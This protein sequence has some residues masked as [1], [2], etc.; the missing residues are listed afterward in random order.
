VLRLYPGNDS[1]Y[2]AGQM[3]RAGGPLFI[4]FESMGGQSGPLSYGDGTVFGDGKWHKLEIYIK[5]NTSAGND[6]IARVW[7][8]GVKQV[9]A[10]NAKTVTA[11]TKWS[12]LELMSN[13][14]SNPGWEH[15]ANNHVYWDNI[16]VFTDTGTGASGSMADATISASGDT[17]VPSPPQNVSVQ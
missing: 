5:E 10:V 13:W 3:E 16:E 11:G 8:D 7:R 17:K 15:D 9:E 1:F 14:S 12:H 4:Y 6:G 2:V